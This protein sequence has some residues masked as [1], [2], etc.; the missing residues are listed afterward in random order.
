MLL[1]GKTRINSEEIVSVRVFLTIV[2]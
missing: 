1:S 2:K